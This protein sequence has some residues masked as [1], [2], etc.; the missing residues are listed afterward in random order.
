MADAGHARPGRLVR[1]ADAKVVTVD[2]LLPDEVERFPWA[3][4]LGL[5]LLPQVIAAVESTGRRGA[6]WSSPTPGRRRRSGTRRS[7]RRGR[8]GPGSW[9]CTTG[10]ST[11]RCA[12]WW[13]RGCGAATCGAWSAR[14]ASTWGSTSRRSTGWCRSGAPREWRGCSSAPVAAGT[15]PGAA[16]RVTCVPTHAFELVEVAAA[17]R[18]LLGRTVGAARAAG[19]AARRPRPAPGDGGPG[20]RLR[21][22]GAAGRGAD[23]PCLPRPDRRR[24]GVGAR[25]RDARR[26]GAGRLPGVP[27]GGLG[28]CW[29]RGERRPL[30]GAGP[31]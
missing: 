26:T 23:G 9:R 17:R 28:S 21:G 18:A 14:R 5:R 4:H 12:T 13:R 15:A 24:V 3:G 27:P 20:R 19:Q 29:R 8:T 11:A 31:R 7:W 16:S 30:R 1:G 22:A 25:L 10:R 2:S 6:R